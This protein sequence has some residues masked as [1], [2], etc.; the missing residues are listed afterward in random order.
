[1][2]SDFGDWIGPMLVK[3]LRQGLKSRGF[4]LS[5]V[6][7]QAALVLLITFSVLGYLN[8]PDAF[9]TRELSGYFWLVTTVMLLVIT[10]LRAFND[11]AGERKANTLELL[12]MSGLTSWRIALGKWS[13]LVFQSWLFVLA[14]LPYAVLR[15]Y[16]GGVQLAEEGLALLWM[17]LA[18]A[19]LTALGLAISGLPNGVRLLCTGAVC[20]LFL[21]LLIVVGEIVGG[22][23]GPFGS[24]LPFGNLG[25]ASGA[26]LVLNILILIVGTLCVAASTIAPLAENQQGRVRGLAVCGMLFAAALGWLGVF[27]TNTQMAVV[28]LFAFLGLAVAGV[29]LATAPAP[30]HAHLEPFARFGKL[31]WLAGSWLQPGWPGAILFVLVLE[32]LM[33][34]LTRPFSI[35]VTASIGAVHGVLAAALITPPLLRALAQRRIKYPLVTDFLIH[36]LSCAFI[37]GWAQVSN[38]SVQSHYLLLFPPAGFWAMFHHDDARRP[39]QPEVWLSWGLGVLVCLGLLGLLCSRGYWRKIAGLSAEVAAARRA[40]TASKPAALP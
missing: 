29:H 33:L 36:S 17:L 1:M 39:F 6:L 13:S 37:S 8:N 11:L 23:T 4:G 19:L 14:L 40:R 15:Y 20:I 12:Y 3:E 26:G 25:Y 35:N 28:W 21:P 2:N 9:K 18:S 7:L 5:F 24:S 27:E 10:P 34:A 30:L 22:R 16:F 31:G 38:V 32:G